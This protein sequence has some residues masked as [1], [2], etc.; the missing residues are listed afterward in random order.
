M[1]YLL[2]THYRMT[3]QDVRALSINDAKQL[4]YWAQAMQGEEQAVQEAVYLGYDVIPEL[5]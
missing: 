5:E 2:M 1:E 3:L 4:L